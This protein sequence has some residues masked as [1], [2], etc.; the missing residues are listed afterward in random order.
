M[1]RRSARD[2]DLAFD[3][4]A[5][6]ATSPLREVAAFLD[7]V[8]LEAAAMPAPTPGP[9]LT[10][11]FDGRRS[12]PHTPTARPAS[13]RPRPHLRL[14]PVTAL[15][16]VTAVTFGGLA[17]AGALPGP[18]QRVS[19]E[20]GMHVGIWLPGTPTP[21]PTAPRQSEPPRL[22]PTTS[23]GVAP[24]T[25]TAGS[26]TTT[27]STTPAGDPAAPSVP[28]TP[29]VPIPL[30]VPEL[31]GPIGPTGIRLPIELLPRPTFRR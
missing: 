13:P 26:E 21:S 9:A 24:A 2:R 25:T 28:P 18:M 19:A 11:I 30:P 16:A 6:A 22:A 29:D 1:I 15:V 4:Q 20:L 14:R 3:G 31:R 7:D 10:A 27:T 5:V 23:A 17:T 12:L 8:R